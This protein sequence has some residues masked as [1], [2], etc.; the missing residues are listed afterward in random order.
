MSRAA[1]W[2]PLLFAEN[3]KATLCR[4]GF[5]LAGGLLVTLLLIF[6]GFFSTAFDS[7][8]VLDSSA[9]RGVSVT[10]PAETPEQESVPQKAVM[11]EVAVPRIAVTQQPVTRLE[12]APV[13]ISYAI[14]PSIPVGVQV[15]APPS[16]E[17]TPEA[18]GVFA[19]GELDAQPHLVHSPLPAYPSR[20]KRMK[21]EGTVLVR[22]V[23]DVEGRVLR[24]RV[25]PGKDVELFG[26]ATLD[27]V[28]R[29]RF[30]P[31]ERGG[32]PVLCEVEVPVVFTLNK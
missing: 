5:S 20:A 24:C 12:L 16:F 25:L 31:G 10:I 30:K 32:R 14:N 18:S 29:W 28:R 26:Q 7:P 19:A 8:P 1:F 2:G 11:Q 23:L 6:A 15:P 27:A 3:R 17:A 21:L 4:N 9:R 13:H 22:L